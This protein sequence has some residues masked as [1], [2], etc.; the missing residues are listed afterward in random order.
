MPI[1][2]YSQPF[3]QAYE[4]TATNTI[5]AGTGA[6]TLMSGMTLTPPA[7]KYLVLFSCDCNS[8]TVG[9][10]TSYSVYVGGSQLGASLVKVQPFD[11]GTLSAGAAR[12]AVGINIIATV[13]GTQAIEIR[14]S[15]SNGTNQ[16]AARVLNLL[17]VTA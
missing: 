12:C 5:T 17:R 2:T 9:A 16:S 11:G 1:V 14:W 3:P 8:S 15:A 7:G 4:A 13:D 6:N 10:A